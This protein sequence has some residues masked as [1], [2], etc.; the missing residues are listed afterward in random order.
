MQDFDE[1][2]PIYIQI[3]EQLEN[4]ILKEEFKSDDMIPSIRAICQA[5][6]VNP[7]TALNAVNELVNEKV[8]FKKRGIGIFVEKKAKD[9][10]YKDKL[11]KFQNQELQQFVIKAKTLGLEK[12]DLINV[13]R[14]VYD[15]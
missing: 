11:K 10:I 5:Y 14:N 12:N 2:I 13:I 6:R 8:L 15:N 3:K 9:I 4:A 7:Q 1:N